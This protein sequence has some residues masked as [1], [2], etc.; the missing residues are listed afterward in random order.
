MDSSITQQ[1]SEP[2]LL[3]HL[4]PEQ[5]AKLLKANEAIVKKKVQSQH[6]QHHDT[7]AKEK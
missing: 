7:F 5:K 1:H 3:A 2:P 6:M 4:N